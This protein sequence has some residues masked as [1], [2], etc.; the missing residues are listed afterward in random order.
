MLW[1]LTSCEDNKFYQ[2]IILDKET[3]KPIS[4]TLPFHIN[5]TDNI[6][7]N[8][9][10]NDNIISIYFI[11]NEELYKL[12]ISIDKISKLICIIKYDN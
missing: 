11:E 5:N 7:K 8:I 1:C 10:I 6:C 12:N 9:V 4:Y 3:Y 2:F